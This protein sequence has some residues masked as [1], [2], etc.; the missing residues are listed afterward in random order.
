[1]ALPDQNGTDSNKGSR[2]KTQLIRGGIAGLFV[3]IGSVVAGLV[4]SIVLAR[5]LGPGSYGVYAFVFSLITL[6]SLPVKMG[7]PTLI[8]RETAKADQAKE[9]SLMFGVWRWSDRMMA[10]MTVATLSV[11]VLYFWLSSEDQNSKRNALVFALPLIP[12]IGFAE[13]RGAAVRGLRHV[14]LG[15]IPNKILRPSLLA[16]AVLFA[17]FW[18]STPLNAT[19][20]FGIHIAI[21]SIT[22]LVA[23]FIRRHVKSSDGK[24]VK[25]QNTETTRAW[26]K[27]IL[28]LSVI[29]G[30]QA[31]SHNT[32]ILMLGVMAQDVDTGLYRVA[33]SGATIAIFG[34]TTVNLV[35]QPYFARAWGAKDQTQ[36][37]KLASFGARV[38]VASTLP[39][40]VVFW[41]GG[42]WLLTFVYGAEYAGAF[43][44]LIILCLS[45]VLSAFFG[46]VG[47][48][49]TMS[50]REWIALTGLALSTAINVFLN[51]MLIPRYGIEGAAVATG[52]SITVWNIGLWAAAWRVMQI[53]S[54]PIGFR[55]WTKEKFL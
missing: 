18:I 33:L 19:Q 40:L 52:V 4:A 17:S 1:M 39:V 5:T 6:L 2:L 29:A 55:I 35:L 11:I 41:F 51:W 20:V 34:L 21:A 14:A 45:Q 16:L 13:A 43:W 22:L 23:I 12:L 27:A 49:L 7:L 10:V 26:L 32:D 24:L 3:R 36:L 30:L 8:I 54:S 28:P 42:T 44:A 37:Q 53:D 50:G 46:S 47:N 15:S 9:E 48:L 38:S 31:I 25:G